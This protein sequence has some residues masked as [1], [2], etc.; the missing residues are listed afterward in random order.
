MMNTS[1]IH[2]CMEQFSLKTNWKLAERFLYNQGYGKNTHVI[3]QEGK[4]IRSE[5]VPLGEDSGKEELIQMDTH[6]E[7]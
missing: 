3:R 2:L 7:E 4:A 6:L 5:P 1:K